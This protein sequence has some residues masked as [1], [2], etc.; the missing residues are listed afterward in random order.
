MY[1]TERQI[2]K[3]FRNFL[4]LVLL[5]CTFSAH[6][7]SSGSSSGFYI[8]ETFFPVYVNYNDTSSF[9]TAPGVA[10]TSG[11]GTD[12]RTGLGYTFNFGL[13]V[14][15]TYN[16]YNLSTKRD[17]VAGGD[18]GEEETTSKSEYGPTVGYMNNGWRFLLTVF[19]DGNK[20]VTT[21]N[22]DET[23]AST[24]EKVIKNSKMSGIQLAVGYTFNFGPHFQLG[25]SLIYRSVSYANQAREDSGTETYADSSLYTKAVEANLTPMLSMSFRF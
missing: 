20:K 17:A 16:M 22:F 6:A 7:A 9:N 11:L 4:L 15:A 2:M 8:D 23:G 3:Q 19:L 14:G 1:Q 24:G 18:N 25:P 10:T 21:K 5:T 12:F 13:Y